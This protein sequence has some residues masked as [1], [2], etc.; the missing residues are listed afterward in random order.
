MSNI[1]KPRRNSV[2]TGDPHGF[3]RYEFAV[4]EALHVLGLPLH[5]PG[6]E[7]Y[8]LSLV[9]GQPQAFQG[10]LFGIFQREFSAGPKS[11]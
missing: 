5:V 4:V 1:R 10:R 9:Q 7:Q 8:F 2:L 11:D 3:S 6:I